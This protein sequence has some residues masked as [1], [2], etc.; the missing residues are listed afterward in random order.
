[1]FPRRVGGL[2]RKSSP[3]Q[4][5]GSIEP[6]GVA[7]ESDE[8]SNFPPWLAFGVGGVFGFVGCWFWIGARSKLR[9]ESRKSNS[10]IYSPEDLNS[11]EKV[12]FL[13]SRLDWIRRKQKTSETFWKKVKPRKL[14]FKRD[15][16]VQCEF[17]DC[18]IHLFASKVTVGFVIELATDSKEQQEA[19]YLEDLGTM[20][21]TGLF[22][23]YRAELTSEEFKQI[24]N[25]LKEIWDA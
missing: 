1:L 23:V 9:N 2:I 18:Q 14:S 8:A 10:I 19:R 7:I 24:E 16:M 3:P 15:F 22:S 17:D 12:S 21:T 5:G 25:K 11:A 20:I 13:I 4:P 6:P